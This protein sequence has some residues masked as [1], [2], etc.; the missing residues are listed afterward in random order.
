M[1]LSV[2]RYNNKITRITITH[3]YTS[4]KY[5][6]IDII[7]PPTPINI[8]LNQEITLRCTAVAQHI[9]WRVNGMNVDEILDSAFE[10]QIVRDNATGGINGSLRI[11]GTPSTNRSLIDCSAI[12]QSHG[13]FSSAIS[14]QVLIQVQG[15]LDSVENL[16]VN[17]Q[18]KRVKLIWDPP[19]TIKG[20]SATHYEVIIGILVSFSTNRTTIIHS[21]DELLAYDDINYTACV[22]PVNIAGVGAETKI[23]ARVTPLVLQGII[24]TSICMQVCKSTYNIIYSLVILVYKSCRSKNTYHSMFCMMQHACMHMHA[25]TYDTNHAYSYNELSL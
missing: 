17:I 10:S 23:N 22:R 1:L 18:K 21:L 4:K 2:S 3:L 15:V 8:S 19:H 25:G 12:H 14:E 9:I 7:H 20:V 16:V 11:L 6:Y 13:V 5:S 24:I